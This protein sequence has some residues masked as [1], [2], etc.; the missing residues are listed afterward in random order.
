[1]DRAQA[2]CIPEPSCGAGTLEEQGT[3]RGVTGHPPPAGHRPGTGSGDAAEAAAMPVS[4]ATSALG[5][6]WR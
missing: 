4:M 5:A 3:S 2:L 1:M 6:R